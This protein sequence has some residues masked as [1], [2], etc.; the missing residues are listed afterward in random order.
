MI[1][2]ATKQA[3]AASFSRNN[4]PITRNETK[5]K[6]ESDFYEAVGCVTELKVLL[7]I[8]SYIISVFKPKIV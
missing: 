1:D 8:A 4:F 3:Y 7:F 6:K 2:K 5:W